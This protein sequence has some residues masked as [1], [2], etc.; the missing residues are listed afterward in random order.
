MPRRTSSSG[1]ESRSALCAMPAVSTLMSVVG[2]HHDE[3]HERGKRQRDAVLERMVRARD[4]GWWRSASTAR[5]CRAPAAARSGTARSPG[6]R[7]TRGGATVPVGGRTRHRPVGPAAT[8]DARPSA[9]W[10]TAVL[11]AAT[12]PGTS[13]VG[14]GTAKRKLR[15]VGVAPRLEGHAAWACSTRLPAASSSSRWMF[16]CDRRVGLRRHRAAL[17]EHDAPRQALAQF[18]DQHTA[19]HRRQRLAP[20]VVR[21]HIQPVVLRRADDLRAL[22][23]SRDGDLLQQD[24]LRPAGLLWA[25]VRARSCRAP[26]WAKSS[27]ECGDQRQPG[28]T[29]TTL[30]TGHSTP[31]AGR[32]LIRASGWRAS[33][34]ASER[35]ERIASF[36]CT[37]SRSRSRLNCVLSP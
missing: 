6:I 4:G 23:I 33:R 5:S 29:P 16:S 36:T 30:C 9:S 17:A 10:P 21:H 22:Q 14:G 7:E 34:S 35:I 8:M 1:P 12:S 18:L 19:Q 15:S 26:D 31:P 27:G 13:G 3:Q 37:S 24:H 32:P 11:I 28:E 20:P 2:A 25:G